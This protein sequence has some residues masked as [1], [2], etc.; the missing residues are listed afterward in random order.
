L[1]KHVFLLLVC[2]AAA[3]EPARAGDKVVA[4]NYR[5]FWLWGGVEARPFL[6]RAEAIYLLQGEIGADASSDGAVAVTLR[7]AVSPGAHRAP[8]YLVYRVRS[9]DFTPR[10]YEVIRARLARWRRE[11]GEVRGVQIDFDAKTRHLDD[12]AS[13]LRDFRRGLPA[14]AKLG[15]TGL[16]D[17]ASQAAPEDLARLAGVV[18]EIVF[19]TY[20]GRATVRDIDA[21]LARLSRLAIPFKLGLVE[22]GYWREPAS[23]A[24]NPNFR[25]YVVFLV[26]RAAD[27]RESPTQG[28]RPV[29][30]AT[31]SSR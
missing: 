22:G 7:S 3:L 28:Q 26:N 10:I 4:E 30:R 19:Q 15:V 14:G 24:G 6:E 13:F 8:L 27:T 23:L 21:Y 25:G 17:W 2:L 29:A 12:Y 9:L 5:E 16:M 11:P 18:D 31:P 20:R 1:V